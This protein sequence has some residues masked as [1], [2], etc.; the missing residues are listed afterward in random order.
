MTVRVGKVEFTGVQNIR[1]EEARILVEQRVPDQQGASFQDLGRDPVTIVMDGVLFGEQVLEALEE[2]RRAQADAEPLPFAADI[3]VGTDLTDVIIED[4]KLRQLAGYRDRYS[5]ALRLREHLEPPQPAD[6]S[7][8]AVNDGVAADGA[9]WAGGSLAAASALQ[10]PAAVPQ[11]LAEQPGMLDALAMDDLGASMAQNMDALSG[12]EIGGVLSAVSGV[13]PGKATELLSALRD[14]NSLGAMLS[15]YVAEGRDLLADL[16][17]L[18]LSK[19]AALVK[20]LQGGLDFLKKLKAVADAAGTL[21]GE[22]K[23]F[24]PLAGLRPL[25]DGT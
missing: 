16:Q 20:A 10:D 22:I 15:K 8:A 4:V 7:L 24:D 2:L 19:A 13:D 12:A 18:D 6:A 3:A 1:T 5:F 14:T 21:A 25:L 11:L 17:G 9:T 23:D